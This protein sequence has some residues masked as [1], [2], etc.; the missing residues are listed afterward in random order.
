MNGIACNNPSK[1]WVPVRNKPRAVTG[2]Y[3][4]TYGFQTLTAKD[5][6]EKRIEQLSRQLQDQAPHLL[7]QYD[8]LQKAFRGTEVIQ[9]AISTQSS[10]QEAYSLPSDLSALAKQFMAMEAMGKVDFTALLG[11]DWID[12]APL[13]GHLD[14][15]LALQQLANQWH[16][17][18]HDPDL[19]GGLSLRDAISKTHRREALQQNWPHSSYR[20]RQKSTAW[21]A[22][23]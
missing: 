12:L 14:D 16:R 23:R 7:T 11:R 1:H 13:E 8:L 21:K 22:A 20:N 10:V 6:L 15:A 2:A 19:N 17:R 18:L 4:Q 3:G 9:R 5:E